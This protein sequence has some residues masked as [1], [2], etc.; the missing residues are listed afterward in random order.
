[1]KL[2][3]LY[4]IEFNNNCLKKNEVEIIGVFQEKKRAIEI[5]NE[6][7]KGIEIAND[8]E[9]YSDDR[10]CYYS[11]NDGMRDYYYCIEKVE[12]DKSSYDSN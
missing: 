4:W 1:M 9:D 8:R 12:L 6:K 7:K 5:A 3:V 10:R 2:Y 11:Y